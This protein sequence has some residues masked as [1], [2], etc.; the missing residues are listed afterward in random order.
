MSLHSRRS[1]ELVLVHLGRKRILC[2]MII[3]LRKGNCQ[4]SWRAAAKLLAAWVRPGSQEQ[5]CNA[6]HSCRIDPSRGLTASGSQMVQPLPPLT[7]TDILSVLVLCAPGF[8]Y[9]ATSIAASEHFL[10][11]SLLVALVPGAR[12]SKGAFLAARSY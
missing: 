4:E 11:S 1:Q 6:A 10:W 7:G 9:S 2:D 5:C 8:W 3:P 12:Q